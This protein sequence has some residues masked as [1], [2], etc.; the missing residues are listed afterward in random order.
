MIVSFGKLEKARFSA[1]NQK[2]ITNTYYVRT[3]EYK[4]FFDGG[5]ASVDVTTAKVSFTKSR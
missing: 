3:Y 5:G 1:Q 4:S 2:F